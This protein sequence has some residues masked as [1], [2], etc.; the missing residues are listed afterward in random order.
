MR[1]HKINQEQDAEKG[2][3]KRQRN[4]LHNMNF[5]IKGS[6]RKHKNVS[7]VVKP[8]L[9]IELI[10]CD[11]NINTIHSFVIDVPSLMQNTLNST[12]ANTTVTVTS[13]TTTAESA[14]PIT[15]STRTIT[16][17]DAEPGPSG[18]SFTLTSKAV[19]VADVSLNTN[20]VHHV[21]DNQA[22]HTGIAAVL[23]CV[24]YDD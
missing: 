21:H 11:G 8:R 3:A 7:Y 14:T 24:V 12:L 20:D 13:T 19:V 2:E 9:E 6:E 5:F 16:T 4:T 1:K 10:A 18:I 17:A 15:T 23:H 22:T